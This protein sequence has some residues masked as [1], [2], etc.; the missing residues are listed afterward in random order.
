MVSEK[1][2]EKNTTPSSTS[3]YTWKSLR[4]RAF[5]PDFIDIYPYLTQK[6]AAETRKN[7]KNGSK[8]RSH[9]VWERFLNHKMRFS[10]AKSACFGSEKDFFSTSELLISKKTEI[11][12]KK[13][14]QQG[15][16]YDRLSKYSFSHAVYCLWITYKK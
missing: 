5:Y 2:W 13:C 3:G 14:L 11:H 8:K 9:V 1:F 10:R 6:M 16:Q 15:F 12:N 7:Q 4:H